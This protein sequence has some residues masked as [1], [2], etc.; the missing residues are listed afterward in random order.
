MQ[1]H[2]FPCRIYLTFMNREQDMKLNSERPGLPSICTPRGVWERMVAKYNSWQKYIHCEVAFPFDAVR[3][4]RRKPGSSKALM[5][6]DSR[7]SKA[8]EN[9]VAF[10]SFKHTGVKKIERSFSNKAY[11]YYTLKLT[12]TEFDKAL[13]FAARCR[14]MP[15]DD[16]ASARVVCWPPA[17]DGTKWWCA[18]LTHAILQRAGFLKNYALNTLDVDDIEKLMRR[19][20]RSVES[21]LPVD[22][23]SGK[24]A[25]S[26]LFDSNYTSHRHG[27]LANAAYTWGGAAISSCD[28]R[29][30]E[31][32]PE[33]ADDDD[34]AS[35]D[36]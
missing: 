18:S 16:A 8:E 19:H 3:Q 14:G 2:A 17:S 4:A 35:R 15:Y 36:E 10:A 13:R 26:R 22:R 1:V 29:M 9:V 33:F 23:Q 24:A 27:T 25:V 21:A 12:R 34:D 5:I 6:L 7:G 31:L 30:A 28:S 20:N 11:R 32:D